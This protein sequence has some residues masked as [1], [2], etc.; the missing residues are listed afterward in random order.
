MKKGILSVFIC[1]GLVVGSPGKA[2]AQINIIGEIL[3]RVIMAIDLKVQQA[4]T[5]TIV[6]QEGQKQLENVMQE[7]RL[8]D[9]TDWVRQQKEL[10]DAYYQELWQVKNVLRYYS[11]VKAMIDRQARMIDGYKRA[12]AAVNRDP[13]FS[14]EEVGHMIMVY[15][16]ILDASTA[17]TDELG[18]LINAFSTQM[19]DADRLAM[20]NNLSAGIDRS[21][22]QLQ[23]YTQENMLLSLQRAK[24]QGDIIMIKGL[25][26][27]Q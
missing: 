11:A 25:Y 14:A 13:H 12:F 6:L 7:T 9:I 16:S 15:K 10:Y 3:K 17:L 22:R 2:A 4:Q 23:L 24:G 21:Y 19:D 26:E 8:A 1:L 27:I 18:I 20:I 5:K